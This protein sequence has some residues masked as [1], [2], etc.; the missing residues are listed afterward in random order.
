[1]LKRVV[2]SFLLSSRGRA[3]VDFC[4]EHVPYLRQWQ[5]FEY[6]QQFSKI[7]RWSRIFEGVYPTFAEATRAIPPTKKAGYDNADS[8]GVLAPSGP[9]LPSDYPVL[10]WLTKLFE[11]KPRRLFDVGGYVGISFYSYQGYL[12]YPPGLEWVIYDVPAVTA[13]GE[14]LVRARNAAGLSFSTNFNDA[15]GADIL[16]AAGSL[17]FIETPFAQLLAGLKRLAN[18][19]SCS[20]TYVVFCQN[21]DL[22]GSGGG[23]CP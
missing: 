12:S 2:R 19:L 6:H 23:V 13:A 17:Q 9:L 15:D 14:R 10:F 18:P 5:R 8:A 21:I 3:L 1:M 20:G 11:D 22:S 4:E 7:T 16:L